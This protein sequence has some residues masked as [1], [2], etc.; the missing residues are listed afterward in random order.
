MTVTNYRKFTCTIDGHNKY[1][2]V[3]YEDKPYEVLVTAWG[4]IGA[5][6]QKN[7]KV[8]SG[9]KRETTYKKLIQTKKDKGYK[10]VTNN[11]T[12]LPAKTNMEAGEVKDS[13]FY[14]TK[15]NGVEFIRLNEEDYCSKVSDKLYLGRLSQ[16]KLGQRKIYVTKESLQEIIFWDTSKGI[17]IPGYLHIRSVIENEKEKLSVSG[18]PGGKWHPSETINLSREEWKYLYT[19][20]TGNKIVEKKEIVEKKVVQH[21]FSLT[22]IID[23]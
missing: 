2:E 23:L 16:L 9:W 20:M 1:W 19:W 13:Y 17:S 8:C 4:K 15:I 10:E 11:I 12:S 3:W 14:P 21:A 18:S 22:D 6:P 7:L 5:V